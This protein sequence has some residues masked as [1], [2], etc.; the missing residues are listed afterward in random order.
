MM[1]VIRIQRESLPEGA[2]EAL[3]RGRVNEAIRA[4]RAAESIG[5]R[6]AKR[7]VEAYI[8]ADP[9]L[10]GAFEMRQAAALCTLRRVVRVLALLCGAAVGWA[11]I[12]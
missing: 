12:D 6:E 8:L 7:I 5:F 1:G 11:I 2:V 10:R 3:L 4:V 9:A